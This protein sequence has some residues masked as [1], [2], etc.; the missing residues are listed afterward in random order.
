MP[1]R[2]SKGVWVSADSPTIGVWG[3]APAA[4]FAFL[5]LF[6]MKF[7]VISNTYISRDIRITRAC[8]DDEKLFILHN[9]MVPTAQQFNS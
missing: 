3:E 2:D 9:A 7:I 1:S 8:M 5:R 6:S 4:F